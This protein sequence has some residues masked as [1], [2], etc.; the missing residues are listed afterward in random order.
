MSRACFAIHPTHIVDLYQ[1]AA[2]EL[3]FAV[4]ELRTSFGSLAQE[5]GT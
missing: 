4:R 5:P 1:R 2:R 3:P